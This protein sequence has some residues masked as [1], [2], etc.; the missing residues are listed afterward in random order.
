MKNDKT[1]HVAQENNANVN[2]KEQKD[3]LTAAMLSLFL[4][5]LGVDRF[6]LGK[7]GTGVLKLITLGGCGIWYLID[8]IIIL[9]GSAKSSDGQSLKNREK[10]IKTAVLITAIV[11]LVGFILSIT[12]NI[13]S[14]KTTTQKSSGQ[15]S[16]NPTSDSPTPTT[17]KQQ[18]SIATPT[19]PSET[20]SQKNAIRKAKEYLSYSSFSYEGLITQLEFEKFSHEDA[21]YGAD[22][23]GADWNEQAAKKAKEYMSYSS[24]SRGSLITQLE[25]DKFTTDQATHGANIVGL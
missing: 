11:F 14:H 10:N 18:E 2:S 16:Q 24:F 5:G 25:F 6:Y 4:G 1:E 15:T 19:T 12:T 8:L 3:F 9:A 23:S 22:R 21:V 20:V 7:V 13:T 17:T